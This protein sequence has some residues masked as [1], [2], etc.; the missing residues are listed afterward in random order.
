MFFLKDYWVA[1][2]LS[3]EVCDFDLA[4]D[5]TCSTSSIINL[6]AISFDRFFTVTSLIIFSQ[7]RHN[8]KPAYAVVLLCW[9]T[10]LAIRLPIMFG[11]NIGHKMTVCK[12]YKETKTEK[13][14]THLLFHKFPPS[15]SSLSN[16]SL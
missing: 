9:C 5:V 6:V 13:V 14:H 11:L 2:V 7:H 15:N 4:M 16:R 12:R 10:S 8:P 3:D 1:W